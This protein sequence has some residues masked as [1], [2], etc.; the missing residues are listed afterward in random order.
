MKQ[1]YLITLSFLLMIF[2]FTYASD[3]LKNQL[4]T[5]IV[6]NIDKSKIDTGNYYSYYVE[7][8]SKFDQLTTNWLR[9][10]DV[11]PIMK[12]EMLAA[13]HEWVSEYQIFQIDSNQYILLAVYSRKSNI[14]FLY[15]E[16]HSD[17]PKK[18]D[19][20]NLT[21]KKQNNWNAE[22]VSVIETIK[23]KMKCI[24]IMQLPQNIFVL[25]E[26]CYWYQYTNNPQD[27]QF[28]FTKENALQIIRQDIKAY[29]N[30]N[31]SLYITPVVD[32]KKDS[33]KKV[34][35]KPTTLPTPLN[36]TWE[37]LSTLG[38]FYNCSLTTK[39]T[40]VVSFMITAEGNVKDV[41]ITSSSGN[42][43]ID[44]EAISMIYRIGKFKPATQDGIPI[45][46]KMSIPININ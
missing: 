37:D 32:V 24:P 7:A 29:L 5:P 1:K 40:I 30:K 43:C 11:A 26:N 3:S 41:N 28:L 13:G 2:K 42:N 25:N 19:R 16:G 31:P 20:Y 45:D 44:E 23:G 38:H 34:S 35:R 27:D 12:E 39:T 36:G 10:H 15:I 21:Q 46:L 9:L 33:I 6:N 14:G 8:S 17:S 22:Y 18:E 4:K